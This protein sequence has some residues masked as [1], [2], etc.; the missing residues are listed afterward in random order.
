MKFTLIGILAAAKC[1]VKREGAN[2]SLE[3]LLR[4]LESKKQSKAAEEITIIDE[5]SL[6]IAFTDLVAHQC[7]SNMVE[8][9]VEKYTEL[10]H[11][12]IE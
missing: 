11:E 3:S 9:V 7:V 12:V 2:E 5:E 10:G 1:F 6:Y 4:D 8:A